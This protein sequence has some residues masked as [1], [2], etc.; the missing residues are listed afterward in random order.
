V[1]FIPVGSVYTIDADQAFELVGRIGPKV[2]IPMHFRT[3]HVTFKL[4]SVE[5]FIM[6][7]PQVER[8]PVFSCS[9]PIPDRPR[10]V[11]LDYLA[12]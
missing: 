1:L 11:V 2:T 12:S 6:K 3:P 7:F 4:D 9:E 10:V 8:L 5:K